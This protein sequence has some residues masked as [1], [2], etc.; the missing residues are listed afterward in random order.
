MTDRPDRLVY[1]IRDGEPLVL[2]VSV[3]HRREV[4]RDL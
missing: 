2:V 3:A 1:A 4:H